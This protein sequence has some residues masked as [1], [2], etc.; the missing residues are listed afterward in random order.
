MM[1]TPLLGIHHV[2]AIVEEP[3]E[4]IDFYTQVLGLRLVKQTVNFDDPYT[5]HLYYGDEQ[6]RP[7]TIVT[8]FPWPAGRRGSRGTG[9]ISAIAFRV[10]AGALGFWQERLSDI[11]WHFGGPEER[12]GAQVLSLYDPAGLLLELVEQPGEERGPASSSSDVPQDAAIR[13]L[14]GVTLTLAQVEATAAFL[15]ERLGFRQLE[16]GQGRWCYAIGAG[17]DTAVVELIGRADVPRGE[18]AAG[19]VHHVAWRVADTP[20]LLDWQAELQRQGANVTAVRDRQYFRSIYFREPGGVLF[21]LATDPP[22]FAIDEAPAALG[23]RLMLP[24]WLEPQRSDI[25]RR[26]PPITVP[27]VNVE[28]HSTTIG[29]HGERSSRRETAPMEKETLSFQHV[30]VPAKEADAPTLLLLHGT[31]GDEHDLL[32]LGRALYPQ[33]ALLSPRGQV[34]ENGMP[35]FFR[36]L[37][38][39]V[40]DLDDLQRRTHDLAAFVAAASE[41]YGFDPR[42]VIAVGYSNGAN[43]AASLLLL[44]PEVL[45]GAALFHAMVPIV[46]EQLPDLGGVPVFMAAGRSD[47]LIPARLTEQLAQM[48]RQAGASVELQWQPGGHALTQAEVLAA[49]SWLR[50]NAAARRGES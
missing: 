33:A 32:D 6:G 31:G 39:G 38:E 30:F 4:N 1:Q 9:Q 16:S 49:T 45:A 47:P 21:E 17:M 28:Q 5:Y 29:S 20:A 41:Q 24:P 13:G 22:G 19:S 27:S 40:F 8:F 46:P 25:E 2:T 34:L 50:A 7:G 11:G 26:L 36:R 14:F 18:V 15:T 42:R 43:I 44:H 3:Q 23:A 10:P 12:S 35:R 37:A 48:L